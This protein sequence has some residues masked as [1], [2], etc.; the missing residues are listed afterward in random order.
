MVRKPQQT[1]AKITVD[2]IIE[3][4]F[5]CMV[6]RGMEGT[7]TRH[8]AEIAGISVGSLYEYFRNKEAIY[9]AMGR[10]FT[11]EV[12]MMLKNVAPLLVQVELEQALEIMFYEFSNLLKR[13]NER[14][15]KCVRYVGAL[16]YEQYVDKMEQGLMELIMRY[17]MN[18]PKYL[19]V[20]NI[21]AMAYICINSGIFPIIRHLIMPNPNISF[22]DMIKGVTR[23]IVSYVN[24]ELAESAKNTE[25]Q[26]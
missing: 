21:P 18:N 22:D 13:D 2:A 16:E 7:T 24:A 5:I 19:R 23:M 3:A 4:G 17:V 8:I 26:N 20:P 11:D 10:H 25:Q 9:A 1:R 15:L 6:E 14:Y 12:L